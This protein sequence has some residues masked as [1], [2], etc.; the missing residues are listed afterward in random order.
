MK[1]LLVLVALLTPVLAH[2]QAPEPPR[3]SATNTVLTLP[4]NTRLYQVLS[5][6][7]NPQAVPYRPHRATVQVVRQVNANW[8]LVV[9]PNHHRCKQGVDYGPD[10]TYYISTTTAAKAKQLVLSSI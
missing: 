10:P 7:A 9:I 8:I 5:D 6:T 4:K 1:S 2:A 3:R